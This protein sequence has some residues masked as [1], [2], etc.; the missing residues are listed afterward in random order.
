MAKL[1]TSQTSLEIRVH[2]HHNSIQYWQSQ[3]AKARLSELVKNAV[4]EGPQGISVRG[5]KEVVV[6]SMQEYEALTKQ[7]QSF[8]QFMQS[9]RFT[10]RKKKNERGKAS[11]RDSGLRG[12]C[13]MRSSV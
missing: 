10:E 2:T 6:I 3:D 11:P 9:S 1:V 5:H 7:Q 8:W 4:S 12:T 13:W